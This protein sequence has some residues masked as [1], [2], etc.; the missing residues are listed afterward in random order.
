MAEFERCE[1]L[2]DGGDRLVMNG[3]RHA[4]D[5]DCQGFGGVVGFYVVTPIMAL[6]EDLTKLGFRHPET[7][8]KIIYALV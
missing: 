5:S 2:Q 7:G 8:A 6:L 4:M 3:G 1:V